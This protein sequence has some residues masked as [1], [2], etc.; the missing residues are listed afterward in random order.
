M[1]K[2]G[3]WTQKCKNTTTTKQKSKDKKSLSEP[4][5]EPGTSSTAV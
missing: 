1:T 5:I 4:E 3:F 2:D